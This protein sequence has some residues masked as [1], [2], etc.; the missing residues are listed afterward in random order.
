M[1]K[2]NKK[3]IPLSSLILRNSPSTIHSAFVDFVNGK[4]IVQIARERKVTS[5]TIHEWKNEF[6]WVQRRAEIMSG[7]S[8]TFRR[9]VSLLL[10]KYQRDSISNQVVVLNGVETS[11][12]KLMKERADNEKEVSLDDMKDVVTCL[13]GINAISETFADRADKLRKALPNESS[14]D[15]IDTT[16]TPIDEDVEISERDYDDDDNNNDEPKTQYRE[17]PASVDAADRAEA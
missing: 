12:A 15:F 9:E 11:L 10:D 2:R 5:K 7:L 13:K 17:T 1:P 6:R 4:P 16:C 3:P 14:G 8:E